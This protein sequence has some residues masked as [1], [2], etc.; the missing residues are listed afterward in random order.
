MTRAHYLL[1][2]LANRGVS[3]AVEGNRLR[4]RPRSAMTDGLIARVL[5]SKRE[6]MVLLRG[7]SAGA[8]IQAAAPLA[9]LQW[10]VLWVLAQTPHLS[11][12]ALYT[13]IPA[14]PEAVD[15][16]L[17]ALLERGEVRAACNGGLE[18]NAC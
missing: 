10:W 12:A 6:L 2:E 3:I 15:G 17:G 11:R 5:A 13:C 16:A 7:T 9:P 1:A 8:K 18:L 4:L 14:P